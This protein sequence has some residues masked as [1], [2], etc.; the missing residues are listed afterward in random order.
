V[1][2]VDTE[3]RESSDRLGRRVFSAM[4]ASACL[5]AGTALLIEGHPRL[6]TLL[7]MLALI[8]ILMHWIADAY[9]GLRRKR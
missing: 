8:G 4:I 1:R 3:S 2:V 7:L 9:R 5:L 6:G